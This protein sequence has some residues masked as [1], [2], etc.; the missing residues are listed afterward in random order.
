MRKKGVLILLVLAIL[1]V[2]SASFVS[3]GVSGG[4][5]GCQAWWNG[6]LGFLGL[7]PIGACPVRQSCM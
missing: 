4:V 6:N 7:T 2:S 3:G 1:L 5:K